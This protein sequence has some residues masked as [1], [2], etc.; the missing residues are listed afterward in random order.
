MSELLGIL[1]ACDEYEDISSC[2]TFDGP[3]GVSPHS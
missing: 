3:V 1:A 2:C